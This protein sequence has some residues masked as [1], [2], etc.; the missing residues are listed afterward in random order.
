MTMTTVGYGDIV[1]NTTLETVIAV[2]GMVVGGFVFA[3]IV[4]S[5]SDLSKRANPG[6]VIRE[7]KYGLVGAMLQD[8]PSQNLDVGLSRKIRAY[9]S[10]HYH[11][12]TAMDFQGF[13]LGCPPDLRDELGF[14][15]QWLDGADRGTGEL[16]LL[17]K[18]PFF[19]GVDP[20]SSI[21]ICSKMRTVLASPVAAE[22]D[23]TRS[24]LIMV[25]G[26]R[27]EQMYV[28]IRVEMEAEDPK[29]IVLEQEGAELGR[30]GMFDYFGELAALLPLAMK[31]HRTRTRTA[32]ATSETHL[33]MLAHDDILQLCAERSEIA[34]K[35][36]PYV[37]QVAASVLAQAP[38][39]DASGSNDSN[40]LRQAQR[41]G[42][43]ADASGA[44]PRGPALT[45]YDIHPVLKAIQPTLNDFDARLKA[46]DEKLDSLLVAK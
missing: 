11:K 15:L 44:L 6:D 22:P 38:K 16:G 17:S 18:M 8:G 36:I 42:G 20:L 33:G 13:I 45:A 21:L 23:G 28:V 46:I 34:E 9:Y 25:E 32:F 14:Q 10:N 39:E 26:T 7:E 4:G 40:L 3:L 19:A 2:A 27:A 31:Q 24:N 41:E 30:L 12:R 1:P 35:V 37:N 29:P 5:L 43:K